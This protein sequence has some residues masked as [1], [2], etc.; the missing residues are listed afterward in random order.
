MEMNIHSEV[1]IEDI[2]LEY[3]GLTEN[4]LKKASGRFLVSMLLHWVS[5]QSPAPQIP[6][7]KQK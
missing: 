4:G 7:V 3:G 6:S 5:F 1:P 2:F